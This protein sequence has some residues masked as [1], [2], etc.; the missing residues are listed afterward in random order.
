MITIKSQREIDL[1]RKAGALAAQLLV[2]AEKALEPG[3]TTKHLDTVIHKFISSHGATPSFLGYGGF[4]ASAC[5]SINDEVIH[6]IPSE[7]RIIND[8]DLVSIDVGVLLNGYHSDTARTFLV[9]NCSDEAKKLV[10]VTKECFYR[11]IANATAG[12]RI[13]DIGS[14]IEDYAIS[15]GFSVVYDYIGHG[16]GTHL[17]EDPDVPNY[18]SPGRGIRL[19]SGM[20]I[21]VEPMVNAGASEV[22]VLSNE[23][24][25]VTTDGRLSAHYE[26][27]IAITDNEPLILTSL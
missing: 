12:K 1:M 3:I 19:R 17:H 5:I 21:A 14:A 26:N 18:G 6:G 2:V 24:T 27:T 11:G 8:G 25:V 4:P 10:E 23:W 9:G 15:N 13:G 16:V 22:R 20:T 7:R